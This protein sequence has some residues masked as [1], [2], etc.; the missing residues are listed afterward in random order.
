MNI[1]CIH[2]RLPIFTLHAAHFPHLSLLFSVPHLWS[3]RL[4]LLLLSFWHPLFFLLPQSPPSHYL[5]CLVLHHHLWNQSLSFF[6]LCLPLVPLSLS[7]SPVLSLLEILHSFSVPL[8][9]TQLPPLFLYAGYILH[10][11]VPFL[12]LSFITVVLSAFLT[13]CHP[14][15]TLSLSQS[16]G[17]MTSIS[18]IC[19]IIQ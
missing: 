4:I 15:V 11:F 5:F 18:V 14:N 2:Q 12:Q 3:T 16:S 17:R 19:S 9:E 1:I 10:A 8:S 6:I 7:L 13:D